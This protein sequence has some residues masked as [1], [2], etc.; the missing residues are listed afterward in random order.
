MGAIP[1]EANLNAEVTYRVFPSF[2]VDTF[3]NRRIESY[4]FVGIGYRPT[5]LSAPILRIIV[6]L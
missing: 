4:L 6:G 2:L 1:G 5:Q 3:S